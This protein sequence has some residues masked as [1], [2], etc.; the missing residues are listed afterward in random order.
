MPWRSHESLGDY[1]AA[2]GQY[3]TAM[4]Q[5][6]LALQSPGIDSS[7][8]A[9]IEARRIQLRQLERQREQFK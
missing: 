5:I 7:S 2:H 4:E 6:H 8:K 1:Y 3:D 9:R